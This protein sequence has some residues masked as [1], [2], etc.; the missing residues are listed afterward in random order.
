MAVRKIGLLTV[1]LF[2]TVTA[3]SGSAQAVIFLL[4]VGPG[5]H[6][7]VRCATEKDFG[8]QKLGRVW[9]SITVDGTVSAGT[10]VQTTCT[11]S[12]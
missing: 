11:A 7:V 2:E 12:A 6:S 8:N 9:R 1:P 4:F 3:W 5:R 10:V